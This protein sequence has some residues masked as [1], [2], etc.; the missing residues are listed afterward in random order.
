VVEVV[1]VEVVRVDVVVMGA[2]VGGV[3]WGWGD[4]PH[5]LARPTNAVSPKPATRRRGLLAA[6][7]SRGS[8]A[9]TSMP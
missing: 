7:R 5:A 8:L 1:L 2:E 6:P 3:L 4:E 9:T